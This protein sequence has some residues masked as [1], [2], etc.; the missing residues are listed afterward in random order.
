MQFEP[1]QL[2]LNTYAFTGHIYLNPKD[3][4]AVQT[5][6]KSRKINQSE[7]HVKANNFVLKAEALEGIE[8]G[9]VGLSSF[10]REMLNVSKLDKVSIGMAAIQD[11][12]PL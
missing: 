12:N 8:T 1:C 9:Q 2:P 3:L 11:L 5:I 4:V 6:A 7:I 10:H